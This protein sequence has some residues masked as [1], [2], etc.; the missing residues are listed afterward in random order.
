M[1]SATTVEPVHIFRIRLDRPEAEVFAYRKWLSDSE[2]ERA[3]K[4]ISAHK[5]REFTITRATLKMILAEMLH[6]DIKNVRI[7]HEKDGR[8]CLVN[9]EHGVRFSV[10]HSCDW[11]MI[12]VTRG[13]EIGID[14]EK[15][16]TDIDYDGLSR[17]FFSPAEYEAL[18]QCNESLRLRAFFAVW[19][20]KE[21]IVKAHGKG[22][23]LGLKNFDVTIEPDQPPRVLAT[24]WQQVDMPDWILLNVNSAPD[25]IASLAA[26]G[27]EI[28]ISYREIPSDRA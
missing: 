25:Y 22:I 2:Q 4:F 23:S 7:S 14:L 6:E 1:D 15:L 19:T 21:A 16:R 9:N 13:R 24:R 3:A 18:Q 28:T 27:G 5:T 17:R 8:P 20:R 10:S 11:A 12:A 26:S